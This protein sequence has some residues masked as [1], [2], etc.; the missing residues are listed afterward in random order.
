MVERSHGDTIGGTHSPRPTSTA[1]VQQSA[2]CLTV[3]PSP[4]PPSPAIDTTVKVEPTRQ[5][6]DTT[7][8]TAQREHFAAHAAEVAAR[9]SKVAQARGESDS[10][11]ASRKQGRA[12]D[13]GSTGPDRGTSSKRRRTSSGPRSRRASAAASSTPTPTR[14]C[15]P[16]R[17]AS[18]S[19]SPS[20]PSSPRK[21]LAAALSEQ[22]A[23]LRNEY[24]VKLSHERNRLNRA[25][26]QSL[27]SQAEAESM[28]ARQALRNESLRLGSVGYQRVGNSFKEYWRNGWAFVDVATRRVRLQ[29]ERARIETAKRETARRRAKLFAT[30][31]KAR[32][33]TTATTS[34]E[35]DDSP[36]S[37]DTDTATVAAEAANIVAQ[38]TLELAEL[39]EQEE[40]LKMRLAAIRREES[41][42][43]D[44]VLRLEA[45]KLLHIREL[46]RVNDEDVAAFG[47]GQMLSGNRYVVL[48]LLRSGGYSQVYLAYDFVECRRVALKMHQLS[49]QWTAVK[50]DNYLRQ[51]MREASLHKPLKHRG[52]V[53]CYD[54]FS[55]NPETFCTVLEHAQGGDLDG[56][57]KKN[58][59]LPEREA[60][61]F[62]RG[63]LDALNYLASLPS[64]II[65]YDLKPGNVLLDDAGRVKLTD[66]G[67]SKT[68]DVGEVSMELTSDA[69]G[70]LWYLPPEVV[71]GVVSRLSAHLKVPAA[72]PTPS[73]AGS[74]GQASTTAPLSMRISSK[75]DVWS[76]GVLFY[77][78]L[79]ARRPFGDGYSQAEFLRRG[80][81]MQPEPVEFPSKPFVSQRAKD[82]LRAML[83]YDEKDRP[84]A[85]ELLEQD[86]WHSSSASRRTTILN[87][88]GSPQS[89]NE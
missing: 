67:L 13:S 69:A 9:L 66:F 28:L 36:R 82:I 46:Q 43:E 50:K 81:L 25:L 1:T 58:G 59:S 70:T 31:K 74:G 42:V 11:E 39:T 8:T 80:A 72:T 26:L 63:I 20:P 22:E 16:P 71:T 83:S 77:Q 62:M 79:Y 56:Y 12:D 51:A 4:P 2:P 3:Q 41:A 76:A 40:V 38:G 10:N 15:A 84:S 53:K 49:A 33:A 73:T 32:L 85:G 52:I 27:V 47:A 65:H 6:P 60:R 88:I 7:I 78:M 30:V 64:P 89:T 21:H 17:H 37:Q 86:Y 61:F 24:E 34:D 18:R 44:E 23:S 68:L 45:E 75:V 87:T 14:G 5:Q 19:A 29:D 54:V 55:V 35:D 57:L 48:R